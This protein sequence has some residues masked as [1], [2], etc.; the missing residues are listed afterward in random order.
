MDIKDRIER[1]MLDMDLGFR[2]VEENTWIIEDELSHIDNM[3]VQF[4]DPIVLFRVKIM[5]IPKE[6]REELYQKLLELNA[7]DLVHGAYAIENN[8]IIIVDTLQAENLD[9]NEFR[10]TIESIGLALTQH[11]VL[12]AK[13]LN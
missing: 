5:D 6:N 10:S 3:V 9:Y 12:L 13:Y 1:F 2:E 8:S 7:N 11:Y 4:T